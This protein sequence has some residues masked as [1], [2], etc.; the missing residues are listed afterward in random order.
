MIR[1]VVIRTFA[2]NR[3]VFREIMRP[4]SR[5]L[6]LRHAMESLRTRGIRH[7]PR[8]LSRNKNVRR[9]PSRFQKKRPRGSGAR[10]ASLTCTQSKPVGHSLS[11]VRER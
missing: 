3:V 5:F 9:Q 1:A 6:Q 8:A 2:V 10:D 7:V 11:L 4:K